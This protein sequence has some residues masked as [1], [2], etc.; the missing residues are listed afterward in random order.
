MIE[1]KV[2]N[3]E[4]PPNH[5]IHHPRVRLDDLHNLRRDTLVHVVWHRDAVVAGSVHRDGGIKPQLPIHLIRRQP[6]RPR[7]QV[8]VQGARS[9]RAKPII[10]S[11][12]ALPIPCPRNPEPTTTSSTLAF[13]PVG[14]S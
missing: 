9:R 11:I 4:L 1:R 10:S 2:Y 13:R 5:L 14:E 8:Q 7:G 12:S 6:F 3:S